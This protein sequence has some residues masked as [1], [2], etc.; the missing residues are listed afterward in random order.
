MPQAF[1]FLRRKVPELMNFQ[2]RALLLDPDIIARSDIGELLNRDMQGKA[3]VCRSRPNNEGFFTSVMLMECGQLK[4]WRWEQHLAEVFRDERP[5]R[6]WLR[7][8]DENPGTIGDLEEE[9]NDF[10]TLTAKTRLLHYTDR[11]TQPW[12]TGLPYR[13]DFA[14]RNSPLHRAKNFLHLT[15]SHRPHRHEDLFFEVLRESIE[16]GEITEDEI[17]E[18][19]RLGFFRTDGPAP[20]RRKPEQREG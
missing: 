10:D 6:P 3:L 12:L 14:S 4:H 20:H 2:G 1:V 7:L 15:G 9:W 11:R 13:D 19:I 8:L 16:H 17:D 18:Q 5:A